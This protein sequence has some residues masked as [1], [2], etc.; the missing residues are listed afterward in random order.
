R[1]LDAADLPGGGSPQLA[2]TLTPLMGLI[3]GSIGPDFV[4]PCVDFELDVTLASTARAAIADCQRMVWTGS[5]WVIGPGPEP[6]GPPS[7]WPDTDA[8][9]GAG[10]KDLRHA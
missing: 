9:I 6:A 4:I 1:L 2:I 5:R 3:K 8:A 7:A 10:Y